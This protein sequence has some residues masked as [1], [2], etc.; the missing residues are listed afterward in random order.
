[1][2]IDFKIHER[3]SDLSGYLGFLTALNIV[4]SC[5]TPHTTGHYIV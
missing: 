2:C 4:G 3:L 1:M 5:P